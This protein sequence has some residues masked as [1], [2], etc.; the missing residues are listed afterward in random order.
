MRLL[1]QMKNPFLCCTSQPNLHIE[2]TTT[3][4]KNN[5][6]N[7]TMNLSPGIKALE[8]PI[9]TQQNTFVEVGDELEKGRIF[10]LDYCNHLLLRKTDDATGFGLVSMLIIH[11]KVT[12]K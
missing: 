1:L 6:Q 5:H 4:K 12:E 10:P 11:T 7:Q 9:I 2:A 3:N 8:E